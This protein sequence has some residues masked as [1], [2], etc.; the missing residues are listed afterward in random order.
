VPVARREQDRH[1]GL[2]QL[3]ECSHHALQASPDLEQRCLVVVKRVQQTEDQRHRRAGPPHIDPQP[4][5]HH[6]LHLIAGE[7]P[8]DEDPLEHAGWSHSL[9]P[10][11]RELGDIIEVEAI[12]AVHDHERDTVEQHVRR[13][14]QRQPEDALVAVQAIELSRRRPAELPAEV[15]VAD[16]QAAMRRLNGESF[17]RSPS[18]SAAV[19]PSSRRSVGGTLTKA[20]TPRSTH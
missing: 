17:A 7:R 6:R 5:R 10:A 1:V 12:S 8:G 14:G 11:A 4:L 19:S 16:G 15:A 20:R 18:I 2:F 13:R 9:S 3:L